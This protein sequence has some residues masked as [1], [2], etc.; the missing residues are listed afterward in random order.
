ML[1]LVLP[2]ALLFS[3]FRLSAQVQTIGD[4][5]FTIRTFL[6]DF[7]VRLPHVEFRDALSLLE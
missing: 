1:R 3:A 6:G 4:A 5:S 7:V 2:L